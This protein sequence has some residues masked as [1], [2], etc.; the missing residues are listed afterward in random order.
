MWNSY[1][2]FV[3][4]TGEERE[5]GADGEAREVHVGESVQRHPT[6]ERTPCHQKTGRAQETVRRN[7][8]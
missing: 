2:L 7:T 5:L 6:D 3:Y 4:L 1:I 8:G